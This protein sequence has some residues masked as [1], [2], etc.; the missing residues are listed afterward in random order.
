MDTRI[1]DKNIDRANLLFDLR[2][3]LFHLFLIGNV[4]GIRCSVIPLFF[5]LC[6]RFVKG[7]L[8]DVAQHHL[9]T[10]VKHTS[11][12]PVA[13]SLGTPRNKCDMAFK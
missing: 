1:V 5:K 8:T 10:G 13:Q 9:C 11:G 2:N 3:C 12:D 6:H 4:K 7:S